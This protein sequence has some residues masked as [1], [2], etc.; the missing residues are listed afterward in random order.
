MR[1][2]EDATMLT[3]LGSEHSADVR[4]SLQAKGRVE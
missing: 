4:K 3:E 2:R 1:C